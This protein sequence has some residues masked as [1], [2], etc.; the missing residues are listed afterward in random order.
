MHQEQDH[1]IKDPAPVS[2]YS[3]EGTRRHSTGTESSSTNK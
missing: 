1:S 3:I 2:D